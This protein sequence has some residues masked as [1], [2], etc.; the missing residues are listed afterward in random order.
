MPTAIVYLHDMGKRLILVF[1][2]IFCFFVLIIIR[3][4]FWQV[5]NIEKLRG[6]AENQ[7][8]TFLTI[9]AKRGEIL[10]TDGTPL[11]MNKPAYLVYL[12]PHK[13]ENKD[14]TV[15][16]LA[17]E[18]GLPSASISAK[19]KE[20]ELRWLPIA[21]KIDEE[22]VAKIKKIGL[23][24][25]GYLEESKRY[26][27]EGSMSAHL[28]GFVGKNTKGEDQ[29]YFGLEGYYEEQLHGRNGYLKQ[30]TDARGNPILSGNLEEVPRKTEGI[31]F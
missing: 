26:Y 11:V 15:E 29:G 14:K 18:L 16:I 21:Q 20:T 12:E 4:F 13:I 3:L 10:A 23:P 24:G 1:I 22:T 9:P 25:V 28:L 5:A 17:S 19:L 7:T 2:G 8:N 30:E 27:P 31:W 6:I